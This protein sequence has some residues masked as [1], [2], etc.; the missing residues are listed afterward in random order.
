VALSADTTVVGAPQ[1]DHPN[2]PNSG[3]AYVFRVHV[4]DVS[5]TG[6]V[7]VLALLL[8]MMGLGGYFVWRR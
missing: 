1:N 8:L 7:G 3:S 6:R 4:V 2:G 5:A